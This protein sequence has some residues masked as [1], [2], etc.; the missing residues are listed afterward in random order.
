M[1][2]PSTTPLNPAQVVDILR[3]LQALDDEIR[4]IRNDRDRLV[5]TLARLKKVLSHLDRELDDKRGK[6]AE[7]ETWHRNKSGELE[8]EREKLNKSKTKLTGVTRSKEFV[9]VNK[10]LEITRK[11]IGQKEEEVA[12]LN[13]AIEEFREAIGKEETKVG[14]LRSQAEHTE[15]DNAERLASLQARISEVDVR[16]NVV[17][18]GLDPA[19]ARRYGQIAAKREGIAVVAVVDGCCAGCHMQLQPRFVESILR[20]SSIA[21]C[22][23]CSRYLYSLT[24]VDPDGNVSAL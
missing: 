23:H 3:K 4:D 10:E 16:R 7:A 20:A 13:K 6:L 21:A 2:A 11:N 22:P 12:N 14:D 5:E 8:G 18:V 9:A 15:R 17:T 24:M 19:I 1:S